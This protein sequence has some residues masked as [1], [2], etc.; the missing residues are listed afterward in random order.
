MSSLIKNLGLLWDVSTAYTRCKVYVNKE[1]AQINHNVQIVFGRTAAEPKDKQKAAQNLLGYIVVIV[2]GTTIACVVIV[3][4]SALVGTLLPFL[5]V[6]YNAQTAE[7]QRKEQEA[8]LRKEQ[9]LRDRNNELTGNIGKLE[10]Q[11]SSLNKRIEELQKEVEA[12]KQEN[13]TLKKNITELSEKETQQL[14]NSEQQQ[15]QQ[16]EIIQKQQK[17]IQGDFSPQRELPVWF[18]SVPARA[19]TTN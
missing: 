8:A 4:V 7:A 14:Q 2:G 11:V 19:L 9:E 17:E 5:T 12:A 13:E 15:L 6:Y 18:Q 16:K 3:K 1:C 10:N